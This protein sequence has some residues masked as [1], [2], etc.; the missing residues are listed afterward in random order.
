[1]SRLDSGIRRLQAQRACI[2]RAAELIRE[3]PGFVFEFGLGNGRT[4]DH[5]RERLAGREIFVFERAV[6]AHP[7]CSPGE[8]HLILGDLRETLPA[9]PPRFRDS[10]A[11]LHMDIGSGERAESERLAA[12]LAPH[13][14]PVMRAGALIASDMPLPFGGWIAQPLPAGI[15]EGRYHFYRVL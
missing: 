7:D 10:V 9:L 2:E 13:I 11:L 3:L 14:A 6:V 8:D 4:F 5:L 15:G 12:E 1:M